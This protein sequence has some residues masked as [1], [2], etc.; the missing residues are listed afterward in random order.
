MAGIRLLTIDEVIKIQKRTLP[1]SGDPHMDRLGGA[2]GRVDTLIQYDSENAD[3]F[4]I[5]SAYLI[6]IAK[7]HAFNDANKRT[8]FQATCVFLLMNR[9]VLLPSVWLVKLTILAAIGD[10]DIKSTATTLKVL[11]NYKNELLQETH[12]GYN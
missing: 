4:T 6:S 12:S 9:V 10:A 1:N 11:S 7:A 8:A 2:L 5:A 3:L